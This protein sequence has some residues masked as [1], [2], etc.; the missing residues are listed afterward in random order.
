MGWERKR[1]QA[2]ELNRLLRGATDTSFMVID[3][4]P[5]AVPQNVRY[6]SPWMQIPDLPRDTASRLIAKR[7]IPQLRAF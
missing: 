6:V 7:R 5:P 4:Q 1:A 2:L 3:G